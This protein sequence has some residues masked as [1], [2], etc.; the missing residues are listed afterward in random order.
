MAEKFIFEFDERGLDR[1]L[2]KV[3]EFRRTIREVGQA[4]DLG[5]G[6]QR[7]FNQF[8]AGTRQ[9]TGR[10]ND[11]RNQIRQLQ[12]ELSSPRFT[13]ELEALANFRFGDRITQQIADAVPGLSRGDTSNVG[14]QRQIQAEAE[15]RIAEQQA[16]QEQ[17]GQRITAAKQEEA[18]LNQILIAE[19]QRLSQERERQANIATL[20]N[21]LEANRADLLNRINQVTPGG[22]RLNLLVTQRE[23]ALLERQAELR[24]QLADEVQRFGRTT[25]RQASET[26]GEE[27]RLSTQLNALLQARARAERDLAA[28]RE[29]AA[30]AG[31]GRPGAF[32]GTTQSEEERTALLRQQETI[33]GRIAQALETVRQLNLA[34]SRVESERIAN[35]ERLQGLQSG[36]TGASRGISEIQNRLALIDEQLA[37]LRTSGDAVADV[38][39]QDILG[40]VEQ[41]AQVLRS[42]QGRDINLLTPEEIQELSEAQN[43]ATELLNTL[44]RFPQEGIPLR[45]NEDELAEVPGLINRILLGATRDFG[46]RFAATLQ[47]AISAALLFGTQRLLREFFDAA[48]EVERTFA[49][50]STS[51]EFDITAER[52]TAEFERQLERVRRQVLLIADDLNALPTE[53]NQ[54]AFQM[55]SRFSDVEAAITATRAQVLATRIATIDQA[56]ALRALT[57]VAEAYGITFASISDD[58][59]RQRLQANLYADALDKATLIQQRFG[60]SVED[61]LEGTGASAEL[62]RSLGFSI[63]EA[64]A[65]VAATVRRTSQSGAQVSDRLGRAFSSLETE[66]VRNELLALANEFD[67]FFL[68]PIDF[69]EGGREVFFA[70]ADQFASLDQQ[71]QNRIAEII[72]QRRETPFIQALLGA[73][74][75]GLVGDISEALED[76]AG[77]AE[78][79]LAVLLDTVQGTIEGISTEFQSLAQNLERLGIITPIK[80]LLGGL[81]GI[82]SVLN[83]IV[84]KVLDFIELLNRVPIPGTSWGLGDALTAMTGLVTAAA[85]FAGIINSI[86]FLAVSQ[87]ATTLLDIFRSIFGFDL[88]GGANVATKA[89]GSVGGLLGLTALTS[90]IKLADGLFGKFAAGFKAFFLNPFA[91]MLTLIETAKVVLAGWI[92]ALVTGN[93]TTGSATV[94]EVG[95][96]L[97][98]ARTAVINGI[99]TL[100]QLGLSGVLA[101]VLPFLG[102][103]VVGVGQLAGRFAIAL[104][105]LATFRIALAGIS[106]LIERLFG[107]QEGPSGPSAQERRDEIQAEAAAAGER[108][109][110]AEAAIKQ[111]NERSKELADTLDDA[112]GALE[113]DAR[114]FAVSFLGPL[115]DLFGGRE[116]FP[117]TREN[118][119]REQ[120]QIGLELA[121]A[122]AVELQEQVN[123]L[124][125][126]LGNTGDELSPALREAQDAINAIF[127]A[128]VEIDPEDP[129]AGRLEEMRALIEAAR[130]LLEEQIPEILG[131]WG[132]VLTPDQIQQALNDLQNDIQL[133]F[134]SIE[135]ARK[136][137]ATLRENALA[138]LAQAQAAGDPA[139]IAAQ[140][141]I[142]RE[143]A[144]NDQQL[145]ERERDAA[146]ERTNLIEDNRARLFAELQILRDFAV[147][148]ANNPNIGP[149]AVKAAQQAVIDAEQAYNRA[150]QEEAIARLQF[151]A[152]TARTFKERIAAL[153]ALFF[154]I[155]AQIEER[156]RAT[157]EALVPD[158]G[159]GIIGNVIESIIESAII[160]SGIISNTAAED[161]RLQAILDAIADEQ[162]RYAQLVARNSTLKNKSSL[163]NI[164]AIAATVNA[165][166]AELDLLRQRGADEQEILAKEIELRDALAQQRL[167]EADRRASFFRLTAGTGDEIKAAQAELRAAQDRLDTI[168]SLGGKDTQA[169]YDAELA[170]LQARQRLAELGLRF[171]DLSRRANSD[172]T[173][174]F[175]QALLDVHAAQ[176]ALRQAT[177]DIERLQAEIALA[178][179]ESRAQREFYDRRISDLDFLFQT[180]QI[181][182]SQYIAALRALQSGIDRTTRQGEELWREIELQIRGLQEDASQAF[183]IPTEI[184]LPTLFEVRRALEADALGV[185]YQ[186]NRT[187]EINVFVSDEV[188]V[189]AVIAAIDSAFGSSIDLEAQRLASGGAGITIGGF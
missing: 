14:A 5:E 70:I 37:I 69:F 82:L 165:L 133:G 183:N 106:T 169:A 140:E 63:E 52:G 18:R 6:F 57:G 29:D 48:V 122:R 139:D 23:N 102:R 176:E 95:L 80:L 92:T 181:G 178:E 4:G 50:I 33:R 3:A 173:D 136:R 145:I 13:S 156:K 105:A 100:Q 41:V 113:A 134:A 27:V 116:A 111:L 25:P 107:D 108:L 127:N 75:E 96:A 170:V 171:A 160:G 129:D 94:T 91:R 123:R 121:F 12:A 28:A 62:F 87:G 167:A 150:L 11:L 49:D 155:Q 9:S 55:V 101:R 132:E 168:L 81:E 117:G 163:D 72:G 65:I 39:G 159:G 38:F 164:A 2:E 1:I 158:I 16:L 88:R 58:T 130:T 21:R 146:I 51:F 40:Q 115:L 138:G 143:I 126:A 186:D 54:A 128:L 46:R 153:Q 15:R 67:S 86:R 187:Q 44:E 35:A 185:N 78:N 45:L 17:L 172:L 77:A 32:V 125:A 83:T 157:A 98:R 42:F 59:E 73:A 179:A 154:A 184:R 112:G 24:Q 20:N 53:V 110:D 43:R 10:L 151:E 174:S 189:N 56:E 8:I 135:D 148:A 147:A 119:E 97:A 104:G 141:R 71:L 114:S 68:R 26:L 142:L 124:D 66:E 120:R 144:L 175:E 131:E 61:V 152:D 103:L 34:I 85:S 74:G 76:S 93:V 89:G 30:Q 90:Q 31:L 60:I 64:F 47:F 19:E 182:R 22:S 118:I 7:F 84:T 36:G 137:L 161:A 166:R 149:E 79:R 180:D 188:D 109:S 99:L 177:G 162:L